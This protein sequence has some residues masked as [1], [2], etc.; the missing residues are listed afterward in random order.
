[1]EKLKLALPVIAVIAFAVY[2]FQKKSAQDAAFTGAAFQGRIVAIGPSGM[3]SGRGTRKAMSADE[4]F[5]VRVEDSAGQN[6]EWFTS[7]MGANTYHIGDGVVKLAGKKAPAIFREGKQVRM[8][9]VAFFL[10]E[11]VPVP[12]GF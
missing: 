11:E 8:S 9:G 6:H 1:M 2:T 3:Q 4:A 5:V 10:N 12:A 7:E